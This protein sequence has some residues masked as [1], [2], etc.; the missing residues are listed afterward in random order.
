MAR[1]SLILK[2][3]KNPTYPKWYRPISLLNV[4]YKIVALFIA[5]RLNRVIG[6]YIVEDQTG[7]L[8]LDNIRK[9]KGVIET[10]QA[11]K[12]PA[13]CTFLDA[14]KT[15]D[16]V[17]WG[18]IRE[19]LERFGIGALLLK[20]IDLIY[21]QQKATIVINGLRYKDLIISRGV[22]QVCPL[23][24]L[25]FNLALGPLAIALRTYQAIEGI[26]A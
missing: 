10:V 11:D 8:M 13:L 7:R 21:C 23:S 6:T 20:W 18:Y 17:E 22:Q 4:D 19:V 5:E 14:E 16:R 12:T 2:E 24:P 26:Y 9:W 3:G 1:L 15:F 25:I